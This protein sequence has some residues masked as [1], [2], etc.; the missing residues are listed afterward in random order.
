M[1]LRSHFFTIKA[2][3][4][5]VFYAFFVLVALLLISIFLIILGDVHLLNYS[6]IVSWLV[7]EVP[8]GIGLWWFL[9][10]RF[11]GRLSEAKDSIEL[12]REYSH[13]MIHYWYLGPR[14]FG[15]FYFIV[16]NTSTQI[17]YDCP[18][19][20]GDLGSRGIIHRVKHKNE[21]EM[22]EYLKAH[23]ITLITRE[24]TFA[25]LNP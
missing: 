2:L 11:H 13:L 17:A 16:E 7:A 22:R 10:D 8:L 19:F 15:F 9:G 23:G 21:A 1:K 12:F 14:P 4:S 5:F 20:L 18:S 25:E 6:E 24:V 3:V